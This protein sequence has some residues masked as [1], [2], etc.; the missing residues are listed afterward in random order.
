MTDRK[1]SREELAYR[2]NGIREPDPVGAVM[3]YGASL[4]TVVLLT[5]LIGSAWFWSR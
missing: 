4:L 3:F 1:Q 2:S 5:V